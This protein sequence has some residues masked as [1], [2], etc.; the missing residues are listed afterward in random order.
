MYFHEQ[1]SRIGI[2]FGGYLINYEEEFQY[3]G[4]T[5]LKK[6]KEIILITGQTLTNS[7][8]SA[9]QKY[10]QSK[11]IQVLGCVLKENNFGNKTILHPTLDEPQ[12][13]PSWHQE[14]HELYKDLTL[15]GYS[16]FTLESIRKSYA[17][18]KEQNPKESVRLKLGNGYNGVDH[19]IIESET[20]LQ[21]VI[22]IVNRFD[23]LEE[24]GVSL[25]LNL[26]N[27]NSY[28]VTRLELNSKVQVTIC[29]QSSLNNTYIGSE[30]IIHPNDEEKLYVEMN[31]KAFSA[32]ESHSKQ[33]NRF[34]TDIVVGSLHTGQKLFGIT[35][36]SLRTGAATIVELEKLTDNLN[37]GVYQIYSDKAI[38]R[39]KKNT[40]ERVLANSDIRIVVL[41][42]YV[43]TLC[44]PISSKHIL[45]TREFKA[46]EGEIMGVPYDKNILFQ[47]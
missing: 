36:L 18:L 47:A 13:I 26:S 8:F 24:V 20:G 1:L 2:E 42:R 31:E 46:I 12:N 37:C 38:S 45:E 27:T 17:K 4:N 19:Y 22:E 7:E 23:E 14:I 15:P 43:I 41:S 9:V 5:L 21:K 3:T 30:L 6:D 44:Y 29:K 39:Q 40:L 35:D 34:N 10:L 16:C 25:E 32:M 28:G 33:L 11:K